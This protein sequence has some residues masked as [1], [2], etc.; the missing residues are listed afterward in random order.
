M[1]CIVGTRRSGRTTALLKVARATGLP[2]VVAT[3]SRASHLRYFAKREGFADIRIECAPSCRGQRS[4]R[5]VLLDDAE[6]ILEAY[7][8]APVAIAAFNADTFD[9]SGVTLLK[10]IAE[11]LKSRRVK[12]PDGIELGGE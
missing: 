7:V 10:L 5:T 6:A 2:V 3:R 12:S 4:F 9:F 1:I 11:W 8:G